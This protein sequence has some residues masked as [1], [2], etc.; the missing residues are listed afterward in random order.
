MIN[1][2]YIG[3]DDCNLDVFVFDVFFMKF[4]DLGYYM[5]CE[6]FD[7]VI[8]FILMFFKVVRFDVWFVDLFN[9]GFGNVVCL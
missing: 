6:V 8:I 2:I 4:V 9:V 5:W 7:C 3:V 1:V